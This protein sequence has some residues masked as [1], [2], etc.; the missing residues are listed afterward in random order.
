MKKAVK[1]VK[2]NVQTWYNNCIMVNYAEI[3]TAAKQANLHKIKQE[4]HFLMSL[5]NIKSG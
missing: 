2:I 3:E 4:K 5:H 1:I